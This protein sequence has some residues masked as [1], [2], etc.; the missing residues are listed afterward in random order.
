MVLVVLKDAAMLY[1]TLDM[2]ITILI[3]NFG[4][5]AQDSLE[6][7]IDQYK[8]FEASTNVLKKLYELGNHLPGNTGIAPPKF[9]RRSPEVMHSISSYAGE[10]DPQLAV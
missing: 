6:N 1:R 10:V 3:D 7:A 5:V 4:E 8:R 2:G 9:T